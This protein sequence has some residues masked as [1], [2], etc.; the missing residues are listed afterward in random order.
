VAGEVRIE[1]CNMD[2]NQSSDD[3]F[4]WR[5]ALHPALEL[6]VSKALPIRSLNRLLG[7]V[8]WIHFVG[9]GR[10]YL[11]FALLRFARRAGVRFTVWPAVH[12][13]SW[14]DDVLDIRL[15]KKA[16]VVMCQTN[17]EQ[18]HLSE[19]GVP[20]RNLFLCGLPPMC[21]ADGNAGSIRRELDL[22]S[23][24]CVLFLGR[25]DEGKGYFALLQ[26]WP[27]VLQSIPDACVLLGGPGDPHQDKL[28]KLPP[29][30]FRDLGPSASGQKPTRWP[31]AT[32]S[33]FHRATSHSALL[34]WKLGRI[35]S[36][37]YA[38]RHLRAESL[39]RM[40][41]VACGRTKIRQTLHKR[42]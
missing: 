33:V 12:P 23:R 10:D 18:R 29:G 5:P 39:L 17:Y 15:Y 27:I 41:G 31:R 3:P 19:L 9:T 37:S 40:D 20:D 6:M 2:Q 38:A 25:K 21:L 7:T 32:F 30:S 11:G 26:S 35:Q 34:T 36:R 24:P 8:D 14:G 28:G 1:S 4:G 42:L 22:G 16:D 13:R